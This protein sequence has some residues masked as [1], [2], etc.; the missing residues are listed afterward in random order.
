VDLWD[1]GALG[2]V[3]VRGMAEAIAVVDA[4]VKAAGVEVHG[5]RRVGNGIVTVS[6]TGDVASVRSGV[7]AARE[8][9]AARA[10]PFSCSVI[11]R[12]AVPG[13]VSATEQ[14]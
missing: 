5:L 14:T 9:C 1:R 3:E 4:V 6:F 8:H 13:W 10:V 2:L 12:P 11:G 7:D